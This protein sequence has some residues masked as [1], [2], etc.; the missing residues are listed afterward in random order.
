MIDGKGWR[1][2]ARW[3]PRADAEWFFRSRISSGELLGCA[4]GLDNWPQSQADAGQLDQAARRG[5]QFAFGLVDGDH[6]PMTR[7][8]VYYHPARHAAGGPA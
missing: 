5:L 8:E 4:D 6:D 3:T 7:I 1:S 2:A